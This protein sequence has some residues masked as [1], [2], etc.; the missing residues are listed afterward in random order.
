MPFPTWDDFLRLALDEIRSCGANSVQVMRRMKAL[1]KNLRAVLP[2]ER[3]MA[4]RHWE[5]R[6]LATI[7]RTFA[8]AEE[9]QEASVADRQGLGIGQENLATA[10]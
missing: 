5:E 8:D 4:L 3:H 6:L 9:K 1:I 7:R 10:A 2:D